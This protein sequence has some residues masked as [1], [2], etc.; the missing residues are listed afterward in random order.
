MIGVMIIFLTGA[1][2]GRMY[3]VAGVI[4]MACALAVYLSF[5]AQRTFRTVG[6]F[7]Q[8]DKQE[9]VRAV[10][11]F[12]ML[13]IMIRLIWIAVHKGSVPYFF[14]LVLLAVD[15]LSQQKTEL[16]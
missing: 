9:R 6:G 16:K 5:C 13:L 10:V 15:F 3:F 7:G 11:W 1:L 2:L 8:A 4:V 14:V 12:A